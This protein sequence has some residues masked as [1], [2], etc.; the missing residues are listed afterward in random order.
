M[1]LL[2]RIGTTAVPNVS[3]QFHLHNRTYQFHII[4]CGN[5]LVQNENR[6]ISHVSDSAKYQKLNKWPHI[7]VFYILTVPSPLYTKMFLKARCNISVCLT[8]SSP[9]FLTS[10]DRN[11]FFI[12]KSVASYMLLFRATS[13]LTNTVLQK[14]NYLSSCS[15]KNEIMYNYQ[16]RLGITF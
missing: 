1:L 4:Q 16:F 2:S 5:F 6:L 11:M 12:S 7:F 3:V 15:L 13:P 8:H 9:S 10:L 14:W